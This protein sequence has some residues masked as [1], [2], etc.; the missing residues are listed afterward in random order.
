M[1]LRDRP[2][3]LVVDDEQPL[4]RLMGTVLG[5]DYEVMTA[6]SGP[7]ALE[8]VGQQR[9]HLVL[10]DARMPGMDGRQ[11][12]TALREKQ[13]KD[14]PIVVISAVRDMPSWAREMK[15]GFLAKPFDIDELLSVAEKYTR[16]ENQDPS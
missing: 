1:P 5:M 7:E 2:T 6:A 11:L 15:L 12:A 4:L 8:K 13:G 10:M 9:P 3:I 14:I 16:L